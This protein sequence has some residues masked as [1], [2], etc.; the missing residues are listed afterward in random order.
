V[1]EK[2]EDRDIA[3]AAVVAQYLIAYQAINSG[4]MFIDWV[5]T[6]ILPLDFPM[7]SLLVARRLTDIL[8]R[9]SSDNSWHKK[10]AKA[11]T[12]RTLLAARATVAQAVIRASMDDPKLIDRLEKMLAY[13]DARLRP[14][15]ALLDGELA[16][17]RTQ[18]SGIMGLAEPDHIL[19]WARVEPHPDQPAVSIYLDSYD[20]HKVAALQEALKE[21]LAVE[22]LDIE[23]LGEPKISSWFGQFKIKSKELVGKEEVASRLQKIEHAIEVAG[24][25][26]PMSEVNVNHADAASKLI[27][28]ATDVDNAIMLVGSVM[29]VKVTDDDGQKKL[30]V[31]TLSV[32]EVRAIEKNAHVLKDPRAALEYLDHLADSDRADVR[33]Q[34]SDR[35][36]IADPEQVSAVQ[37]GHRHPPGADE[38]DM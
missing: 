8:L 7:H 22:G 21:L 29:L 27:Q 6:E 36:S 16:E 19:A 4:E 15:I 1:A 20:E 35:P 34:E 37:I 33:L 5:G 13:S 14:L 24:L 10:L 31:K 3:I 17:Y 12:E 32:A 26:R 11:R 25:Q 23:Q 38:D 30:V 9:S 28:A 2:P 18:G